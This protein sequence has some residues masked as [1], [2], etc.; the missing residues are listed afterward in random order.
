ME[1]VLTGFYDLSG[2][3]TPGTDILSAY[4]IVIKN[5]YSFN[6]RTPHLVSHLVGMADIMT[7]LNAL[8]ADFAF[9]HST[10][11]VLMKNDCQ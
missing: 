1:F 2:S 9:R 4:S 10:I 8:S 7:E 11:P 3:D 5:T 6:V